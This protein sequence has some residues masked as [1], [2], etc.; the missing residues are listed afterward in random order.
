M[1]ESL[2][3]IPLLSVLLLAFAVPL[4]FGRVRILPVVVGEIIAGV[5]IGRSGLGLVQG[6]G[7][8]LEMMSNMGLAFLMFLAGM[9]ID[10]NKLLPARRPAGTP[11]DN[12]LLRLTLLVYLLTLALAVPG[13]FLLSRLGVES[14]PWLLAFILSATSLGVVLPTLKQRELTHTEVGQ[15]IFF[16]ALLADFITVV[17][18]TVFIITLNRGVNLEI[19]SVGLLFLAFFLVYRIG[20][21]FFSIPGVRS[22]IRELS[23]V[24]VQIKVRGAIAALMAFVV[25]AGVLGV[26]LILGAFLA[27]MIISLLK[28]P[29]DME[30]VEKLEAFG[31]GFFIP[32]FFIL[33]GV[34]LNLRALASSPS[35]LLLLPAM[36]LVALIVKT[37]PM[38]LFRRILSWRETLAGAMLLN[39][40]L[41]LEIAVAVIGV[42]LGLLSEAANVTVI[43]FA[44]LTVLVMPV[45][46]NFVMP[47][48][49]DEEQRFILIFGAEDLG[50][51]VATVLEAHGE[52]VRILDPDNRLVEKARNS[53]HET[54]QANSI[55]GFLEAALNEGFIQALLVLSSDDTRNLL[56]SHAAKQLDIE[57]VIALVNQ[58]SMLAEYRALGVQSFNPTMYEPAL[59]AM[60][61]RNRDIFSLLTSTTDHK[62]VREAYLRNPLLN[63]ERLRTLGLPGNLSVLAIGRNGDLIVPHGN[64][65]LELGDRVTLFGNLEEVQEVVSWM[66]TRPPERGS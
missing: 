22:L 7:P 5:I 23:N 17:L 37:L 30:L 36:L 52:R 44:S 10:F 54:V 20:S 28:A 14:N 66:E 49:K 1:E 35:S 2:N 57:H 11:S 6:E 41:S 16:S 26:E 45:L 51:R 18:L 21:R 13:G 9:E 58:P 33:V 15:S 60:M 46:F 29:G 56:V 25:L 19:F 3:F 59:L 39:T 63:G 12:G 24:T 53:G 61:A 32:V 62:D 40:H 55:K 27:G 4:L 42:R 47:E 8:I 34:N 48:K 31:F 38:L 50:R 65:R 43:L 64:T